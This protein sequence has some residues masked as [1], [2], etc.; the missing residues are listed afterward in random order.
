MTARLRW[1]RCLTAAPPFRWRRVRAAACRPVRA[2]RGR[3]SPTIIRSHSSILRRW[4]VKAASSRCRTNRRR[5]RPQ[6]DDSGIARR[7]APVPISRRS[8][9]P[10]PSTDA[11]GPFRP[12]VPVVREGGPPGPPGG[13]A[14]PRWRLSKVRSERAGPTSTEIAIARPRLRGGTIPPAARRPKRRRA[15]RGAARGT[16]LQ[17]VRRLHAGRC[18]A[19][20]AAAA[21]S[22]RPGLPF[23]KHGACVM[24]P[25][26]LR[27]GIG[28]AV[29]C[30]Q[31]EEVVNEP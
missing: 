25:A 1:E 3:I 6:R 17:S 18:S 29:E 7:T 5:A 30:S 8:R 14:A 23:A 24:V 13:R 12:P 10:T 11:V 31:P 15:S 22:G 9:A 4:Q 28:S 27:L 26:P 2:C 19:R 21:T 16:G 20:R